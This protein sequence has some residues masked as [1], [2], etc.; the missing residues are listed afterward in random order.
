MFIFVN[1]FGQG[2]VLPSRC[3]TADDAFAV[4]L[5]AQKSIN[6]RFYVVKGRV[7]PTATARMELSA[8][9]PPDVLYTFAVQYD[10]K[11]RKALMKTVIKRDISRTA[12]LF[13]LFSFLLSVSAGLDNGFSAA[14]IT[15]WIAIAVFG[16][17][18]ALFW[19]PRYKKSGRSESTLTVTFNERACI[20]ERKTETVPHKVILQWR[21]IAH[22]VES[23]EAVEIYNNKQYIYIPK[24]CVGDMD[25]LRSI[26]NEK[27]NARERNE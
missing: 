24:R 4:R 9:T 22:A 7:Q 20:V 26:V 3:L 10:E 17:L 2:I 27:M 11:E 8:V 18:K 13:F 16:G 14:A 19:V 23:E 1:R 21:D 6:P 5:L 25:F 12:P 15:F